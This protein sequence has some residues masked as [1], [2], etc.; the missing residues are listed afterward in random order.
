MIGESPLEGGLQPLPEVHVTQAFVF[1]PAG[2]LALR[3]SSSASI[4]S[5]RRASSMPT[6]TPS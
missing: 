6:R 3:R 2:F 1:A 4:A 5:A